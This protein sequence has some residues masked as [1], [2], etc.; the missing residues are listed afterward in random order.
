ML[1]YDSML[2]DPTAAIR[3]IAAFIGVPLDDALLRL[4]LEH[5]SVEFMRAHARQF[6]D[7]LVREARD[8]ACGPT[9]RQRR[10]QGAQR[11]GRWT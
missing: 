8:P 1:R 7:H 10:P 5:S 4:T 11:Q 2:A 3:R 9:Q 6:D